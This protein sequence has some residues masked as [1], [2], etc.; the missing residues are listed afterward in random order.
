MSYDDCN[1]C[2][3]ND[4][5]HETIDSVDLFAPNLR[6]GRMCPMIPVCF[7]NVVTELGGSASDTVFYCQ[8][9]NANS[10]IRPTTYI[11]SIWN[12]FEFSLYKAEWFKSHYKPFRI[13][14]AT[15]NIKPVNKRAI[16]YVKPSFRNVIL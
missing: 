5:S 2:T 9:Y 15:T 12:I 16:K 13:Q 4:L 1:R 8:C 7:N 14:N 6:V 11:I 10:P 3:F